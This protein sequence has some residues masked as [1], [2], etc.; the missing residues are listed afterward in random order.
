[1]MPHSP[2]CI[3]PLV[4]QGSL[5]RHSRCWRIVGPMIKGSH[6]G[7]ITP[8]ITQGFEGLCQKRQGCSF[9][10]VRDLEIYQ[11]G[12]LPGSIHKLNITY[13]TSNNAL[14]SFD[15]VNYSHFPACRLSLL[16]NSN[17]STRE[18][19]PPRRQES[20]VMR[21]AFPSLSM[22]AALVPL[23]EVLTPFLIAPSAWRN[24]KKTWA[25]NGWLFAYFAALL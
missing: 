13:I 16:W 14:L 7:H 2:C 1:M 18:R 21:T 20:L 17:L 22:E 4:S 8:L 10:K 3:L 11:F 6:P 12:L 23:G 9:L 19:V 5:S 25:K 24:R 15:L